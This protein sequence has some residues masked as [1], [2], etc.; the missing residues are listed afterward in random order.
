MVEVP[1]PHV[2][3]SKKDAKKLDDFMC[4]MERYLQAWTLMDEVMDEVIR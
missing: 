3:S 4:H 2:L 1:K